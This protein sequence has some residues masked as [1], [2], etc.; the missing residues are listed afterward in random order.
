MTLE[1]VY[2]GVALC[3]L[4]LGSAV[5]QKAADTMTFDVVVTD[6]MCMSGNATFNLQGT[7]GLPTPIPV[8]TK[9]ILV[10]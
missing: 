9:P 7:A 10:E 4:M 1:K 2:A 8:L 6:S 3:A 5:A